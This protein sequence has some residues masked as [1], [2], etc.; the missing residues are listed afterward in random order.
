[1]L[2][3][4]RVDLGA[5]RRDVFKLIVGQIGCFLLLSPCWRVLGS[6]ASFHIWL[7]N[8]H[9]NWPSASH[10]VPAVPTSFARLSHM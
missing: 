8:A 9:T 2:S 5:Q 7:D 4:N 10:T 6:K 3:L 1:M